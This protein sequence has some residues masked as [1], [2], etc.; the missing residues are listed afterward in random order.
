MPWIDLSHTIVPD[1]PQWRGDDQPLAIHRQSEHGKDSHM[2]SALQFGCHIGTHIDGPLHFLAGQPGVDAMP[3]DRFAGKALVIDVRQDNGEAAE[4]VAMGCE[5]LP[6]GDLS[7][8]DFVLFLTGWDRHWGQDAYYQEWPYLSEELAQC[9]AQSHLK[10][11]GL[12]TPSLD[13]F[14]GAIAH[15]VCA[16]AGMI[17]I[18]NLTGLAQLPPEGALFQA[19]PLKLLGT[20][21]SPV[22]AAAWVDA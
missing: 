4:P 8:V 22:R 15:D 16:A 5:V 17:N 11:V 10:G 12:D 9:L 13:A 6:E 14:G 20:E 19:L 7:G 1:M 18:E 21:A 3:L 2:S